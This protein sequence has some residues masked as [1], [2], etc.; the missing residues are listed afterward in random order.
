MPRRNIQLLLIDPQSDFMDIA[1]APLTVPGAAM[2]APDQVV[3]AGEA[4]ASQSLRGL[5]PG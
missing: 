5:A 1:G 2:D 3:S 4:T